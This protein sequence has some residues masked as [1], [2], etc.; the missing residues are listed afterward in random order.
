VNNE[1]FKS[2]VKDKYFK[3]ACN[4]KPYM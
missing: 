2:L 4:L 1:T 3:V